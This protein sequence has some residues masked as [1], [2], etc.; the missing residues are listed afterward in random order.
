MSALGRAVCWRFDSDGRRDE[1]A[2]EEADED[3]AQAIV[4]Y[5][6]LGMRAA[7]AMLVLYRAM[8]IDYAR[9]RPLRALD[10]LNEGLALV[11]DRPRVWA[12]LLSH[13]SE[14]ELELGRF[15]DSEAS[16]AETLRVGER[17]N[18]ETLLAYAHWNRAI[19]S[20][21]RGDAEET[22]AEVGVVQS[23]KG[24]WWDYASA[25]FRASAADCLARVGH[26]TIAWELLELAKDDPG[27]AEPLVAMA[28][29]VL[30]ARSGDPE[31]AEVRLTEAPTHGVDPREFWRISL[32][33][34]L[35]A[36]RRGSRE[37]GPL[38]ARAFEE[39][40]R[41]GLAHLPLTKERGVTEQLLGL[42]VE[43]GQPAALA[44]E[45]GVLPTAMRVLGGFSLT[46][47][48][49]EVPLSLGQ[50]R[51]LLKVLA[52]SGGRL[53]SDQMIDALWP[54]AD[55][56]AGRNRLRTVLNRLRAEAGDIVMREGEIL[57]L[58]S[59][60]SVD[61]NE[62]ESD[63][64]RALALGAGEKTLSVARAR[65]AITRYRGDVLPEDPYDEWAVRPRERARR[66]MLQL[67]DLCADVAAARGDLDEMRQVVEMTIDL[68]PY[69]DERYLRAASVLLQQGR[70]G[71]ALAVVRRARSALAEIGLKPPLHLLRLEEDISA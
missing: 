30:L 63:A 36:F 39:A 61:L 53:V 65:A 43:T 50:G 48:G 47:G 67:L 2:L 46:S 56:D 59:D 13:K 4:I 55:F 19:I 25:D 52:V 21:H 18:D 15:D 11:V 60:V 49:R 17:Y 35:A 70:R 14:V 10:R 42:A 29:G 23:H 45:V 38:A 12:L 37:A 69:E 3:L 27:D 66:R 16:V 1:A 9:A 57:A 64:R 51:Q 22:L 24:D 26:T 6:H 20:S 68:A 28:D 8:W 32:F 54:E 71:A 58:R 5:E 40:S 62:F 44:L 41:L 7:S 33:R 31:L 34:A